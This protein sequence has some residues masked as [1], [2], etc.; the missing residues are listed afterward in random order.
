M[1]TLVQKMVAELTHE[2]RLQIIADHQHY[3]RDGFIG[4]C[5]LRTVARK[6]GDQFGVSGLSAPIW[7]EH[8]ANATYRFYAERY[9][10][11]HASLKSSAA[12]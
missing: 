1:S 7:M 2:E 12:E 10:A 9:L 3:E 8:V 5:L 11:E 6:L 4:S